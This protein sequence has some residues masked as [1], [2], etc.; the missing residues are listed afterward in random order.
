LKKKIKTL[1]TVVLMTFI[2]SDQG[3]GGSTLV[4]CPRSDNT[5]GPGGVPEKL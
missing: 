2:R 4:T 1:N 5:K 3:K